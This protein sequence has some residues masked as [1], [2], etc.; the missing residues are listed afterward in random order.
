MEALTPS[1]TAWR[2]IHAGNREVV[3]ALVAPE[4]RAP[5]PELARGLA[6]W[7]GAWYWSRSDHSELTLV[8]SV[9]V[10]R[11]ERWLLHAT[12]LGLTVLCA[13]GA[14]A[15]LGGR[16]FPALP[17][18]VGE[19]P[20]LGLAFFADLVRHPDAWRGWDFALPLLAILLVHESGHYLAA[21]RYAI[22]ASPPYFLPVPATVSPIGSLGAFLKLRSPVVDRRQLLE[23]GA[24]GPLAG[25]A[26]ALVVLIWGYATSTP[27][28]E[29]P[30]IQRAFI[31]FAGYRIALGDSILTGAVREIV[32]PGA[33]S[34]HLSPAAFAGWAG[35]LITGLNLLPLS[36]LDGGHIAYGLFGRGQVPL[37][38]ATVAGLL[39]L[40]QFWIPWLFWV[41]LT[42][43]VGGWRWTHPSVLCP[44]HPV[45]GARRVVG[46]IAAL[47]LVLTFV[48]TPFTS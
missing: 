48:P 38:I 39:Y 17:Q 29:G 14:G 7:T 22:D 23:V 27:L 16:Y 45:T 33:Y 15:A 13:L 3:E 37:A 34:V 47:V 2:V 40:A 5:S 41:G 32:L 11:R 30:G 36:Q 20:R 9:G 46:W 10:E 43:L 28:P 44:E 8:R 18:H 31:E 12:L 19:I 42:L 21:R 1:F 24:A 4:H 35:A 25:F 6:A 26:V